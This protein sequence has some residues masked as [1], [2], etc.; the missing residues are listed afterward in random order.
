[1]DDPLEERL[2]KLVELR[3][4]GIL[5]EAEFR[6]ARKR[7]LQ[8][9]AIPGNRDGALPMKRSVLHSYWPAFVGLAILLLLVIG[10]VVYGQISSRS[11]GVEIDIAG[12][13]ETASVLDADPDNAERCDAV[14]M[15]DQIT[16]TVFDRAVRLYGGDPAPLN[17]LRRA[18]GVRLEGA[19]FRSAE[20]QADRVHCSARL[21][22]D[23]PP[24]AREAF[25]G[26][27]TLEADI[28]YGVSRS[29]SGSASIAE[30]D[31]VDTLVQRLADGASVAEGRQGAAAKTF[32]PSFECAAARS[33]VERMICAD[34]DLSSLDRAIASRYLEYRERLDPD[35]ARALGAS[36]RAFLDR[37]A[38]CLDVACIRDLYV[39][40]GRYLDR[41][42]QVQEGMPD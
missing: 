9:A 11:D 33:D 29:G 6:K 8:A 30:L 22:L 7:L 4:G 26:A 36:Q 21:L 19:A 24:S 12:A 40:Q 20:T 15:R 31:G 18:V 3:N 2:S 37:R 34:E 42:I 25:D 23:V 27:R 1:M 10:L 38:Q 28:A 5:S 17:S 13:N 41:L 35:G 14:D 32:N 16:Q 39:A